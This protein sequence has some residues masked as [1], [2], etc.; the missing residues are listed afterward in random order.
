M[1][2]VA[3]CLCCGRENHVPDR[4]VGSMMWCPG[5][6][7]FFAVVRKQ[8]VTTG[9]PVP[10]RKRGGPPPFVAAC[11]HCGRESHVPAV[12]L[13]T[14]VWCPGCS[15]YFTVAPKKRRSD[16]RV[17]ALAGAGVV[18]QAPAAEELPV[19]RPLEW[20]EEMP[21]LP[22]QAQEPSP[23]PAPEPPPASETPTAPSPAAPTP[24]ALRPL[25]DP[26]VPAVAPEPLGAL[27]LTPTASSPA[28]PAKSAPARRRGRDDDEVRDVDPLGAAALGLGCVALLCASLSALC[29]LLLPLAAL[30]TLAGAGAI[31]HSHR[32]GVSR[33]TFPVAGTS[34][35]A[36]VLL[37]GW[38]FPSWLGPTYQASREP[39]GP[40]REAVRRVTLPG[41]RND[42]GDD[43]A[44]WTDASRAGLAQGSV[45]MHVLK[46]IVERV[47][48]G[49]G[50]KG[51]TVE[52]LVVRVR[53][54]KAADAAEFAAKKSAGPT[55]MARDN[56]P[57]LTDRTGKVY[58]T[59]EVQPPAPVDNTRAG[60]ITFSEWVFVFEAPSPGTPLRLEVPA[61]TWGGTGGYKFALPTTMIQRKTPG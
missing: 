54:Q 19:A 14:F 46:A 59:L 22:A 41:V 40:D 26:P 5:C 44:G 23:P 21:A 20:W 13:G 27:A 3:A 34:V 52:A 39:D 36:V 60:V 29:P 33:L 11:G 37:V 45:Q 18:P 7:S 53:V 48:L 10:A 2:F 31:V 61:A 4:A 56:Y 55:A 1:P 25:R 9:F 17:A 47:Q 15:N 35:A 43:D 51:K 49:S 57:V 50:D 38:L 12:A 30:G 32:T 58:A 8:Q 6:S 24:I 16:V 28:A 42:P